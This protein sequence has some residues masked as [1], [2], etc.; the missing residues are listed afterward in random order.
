MTE[1]EAKT[2]WCPMTRVGHVA[3]MAINRH[4]DERDFYVE[5]RCVASSCMMWRDSYCG[6][7][8][9]PYTAVEANVKLKEAARMHQ[10]KRDA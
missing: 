9:T 1:D 5:T 8:G 3:G 10:G 4:P 7:A 2:K 6:L